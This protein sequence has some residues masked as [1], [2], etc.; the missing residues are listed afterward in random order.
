MDVR[1]TYTRTIRIHGSSTCRTLANLPLKV[2]VHTISQQLYPSV[3]LSDAF[4]AS[5]TFT[6]VFKLDGLACK[7]LAVKHSNQC[8]MPCRMS[9]Q[10][11]LIGFLLS[12][13]LPTPLTAQE[14][15]VVQTTAVAAGTVRFS[16][17]L[18]ARK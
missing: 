1:D 8:W 12:R 10:S 13:T 16:N 18:S 4:Y 11:A 2:L 9:L 7:I 14:V 15:V 5:R 6:L 3:Y 17:V